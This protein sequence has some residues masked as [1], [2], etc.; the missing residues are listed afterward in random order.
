MTIKEECI[1]VCGP[2]RSF[3]G[4]AEYDGEADVFHGEVLGIRDVVTFQGQT[5][6]ELNKAFCDSVDDYISMCEDEGQTPEKPYSGKFLARIPPDVHKNLA[7]MAAS[8]G[9]S[10][11]QFIADRLSQIADVAA[12]VPKAAVKPKRP[13][14]AS[15]RR[16]TPRGEGRPARKR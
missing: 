8:E 11:N 7:R 15:T 6:R 14:T 4:R 1:Y 2:Y 16:R 9:T 3:H 12:V 10:L 13:A 5:V